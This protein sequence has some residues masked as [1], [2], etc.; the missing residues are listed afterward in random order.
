MGHIDHLA[1]PLYAAIAQE[2]RDVRAL[3]EGI[4]DILVADEA[5]VVAYIEQLQSFDLAI[6]RADESADLLDRMATG[7]RAADAIKHVRLTYVQDK[8]TA[9]LASS[10]KHYGTAA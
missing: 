9:A 3:I 4:A 8:L 5:L 1:A 2:I 6:Q 7:A 10:R